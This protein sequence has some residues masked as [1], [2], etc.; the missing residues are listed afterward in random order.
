MREEP[1][2]LAMSTARRGMKPAGVAIVVGAG[3]E[4]VVV[5][6]VAVVVRTLVEVVAE[7]VAV[8]VSRVV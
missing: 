3:V 8:T 5:E 7:G 4:V 6:K 2:G 1:V